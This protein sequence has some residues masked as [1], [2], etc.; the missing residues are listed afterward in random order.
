MVFTVFTK[1][2]PQA[3]IYDGKIGYTPFTTVDALDAP[4]CSGRFLGTPCRRQ[5][6][7]RLRYDFVKEDLFNEA[8]NTFFLSIVMVQLSNL[9]QSSFQKKER[10]KLKEKGL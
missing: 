6:L 10:K 5:L 9:L 3:A 4:G 2:R 7:S 8:Q 1:K